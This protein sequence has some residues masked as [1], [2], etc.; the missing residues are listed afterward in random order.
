M[1]DLEKF[2]SAGGG[3]EGGSVGRDDIL[4]EL[5]IRM[6]FEMTMN[7][8]LCAWFDSKLHIWGKNRKRKLSLGMLMSQNWKNTLFGTNTIHLKCSEVLKTFEKY[9]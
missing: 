3:T 2:S 8:L 4:W 7:K 5:G 9:C 6:F 1:V